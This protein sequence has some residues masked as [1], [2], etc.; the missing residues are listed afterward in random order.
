MP[1]TIAEPV[2]LRVKLTLPEQVI[3]YYEERARATGISLETLLARRLTDTMEQNAQRPI[4]LN[5]TDR[6]ALEKQ[7]GHNLGSPRQLIDAV[8]KLGRI[9][10][11]PIAVNLKEALVARLQSRCPR[12]QKFENFLEQTIV[13]V[14]EQFTGL[15]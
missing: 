15:R 1:A 9:R 5:D 10:V 13:A 14:L 2:S 8:A 3:A 11:G 6:T 12:N 7:L 4:Y